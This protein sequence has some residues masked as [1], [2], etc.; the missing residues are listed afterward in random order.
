MS[1]DVQIAPKTTRL[2]RPI[3]VGQLSDRGNVIVFRS[4]G[5]TI[6]NE[7]SGKRIEFEHSGGVYRLKADTSARRATATGGTKMLKGFE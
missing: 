3:S 5:G 7:R 6:F 1:G 2:Q 4:S